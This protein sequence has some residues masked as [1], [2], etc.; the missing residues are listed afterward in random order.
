MISWSAAITFQNKT[1]FSQTAY[2]CQLFTNKYHSFYVQA[3]SGRSKRRRRR[4]HLELDILFFTD[5]CTTT[6]VCA[7]CGK[8][9]AILTRAINAIWSNIVTRHAK[10][11][12]DQGIK[13][14]V[15]ESNTM[16]LYSKSTR[17][18]KI[19]QFAFYH[20]HW[21]HARKLSNMLW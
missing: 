1:Q 19:V 2:S 20:C 14:C 21:I 11:N 16:R 4:F 5:T 17:L 18:V 7:A 9:V 15:R 12:I 3:H 6:T 10:R 13:V 8:R